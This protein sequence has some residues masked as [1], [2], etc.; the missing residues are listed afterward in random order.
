MSE[1]VSRRDFFKFGG[2][3]AAGAAAAGLGINSI[4]GCSSEKVIAETDFVY[5]CPVCGK[6]FS[7]YDSLAAHFKDTHPDAAI[8]EM[9]VLEINGAEYR[10]QIEPHWTLRETL[11]YAVGLTGNAKEMCGMGACGSCAVL[12]DGEVALSCST[13]AI[14]C[15]GHQIETV[16]GIAADAEWKPLVDAYVKYDTMQCGYCT[17]GQLTVAKYILTQNPDPSEE[18]IRLGLSG[19][20]CRCGTYSR[21][22]TAIQ[23]A[24]K[25][26]RGGA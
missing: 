15:V 14:E 24:A 16:E 7:D 23:E 13:L 6:W 11:Q 20:I 4:A 3:S 12:V 2:L 26:L 25:T 17:P 10:V 9:A 5:T 18:D 19:N 21:H 8:P 1:S 22:V